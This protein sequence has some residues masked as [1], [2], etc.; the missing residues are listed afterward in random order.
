[1]KLEIFPGIETVKDLLQWQE[2]AHLLLVSGKKYSNITRGS[3]CGSRG[4]FAGGYSP[5]N[6][7]Q[8]NVIGY[9]NIDSTGNAI[10]FGDLTVA[11][12]ALGGLA[13]RTRVF[14]GGFVTQQIKIQLICNY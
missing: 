13:S 7:S 10:D 8:S 1:M 4:L 12:I 9:I 5:T 14:G 2:S 11:R 6:P 3:D